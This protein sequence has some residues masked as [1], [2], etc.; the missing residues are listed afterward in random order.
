MKQFQRGSLSISINFAFLLFVGYEQKEEEDDQ[1]SSPVSISVSLSLSVQHMAVINVRLSPTNSSVYQSHIRHSR[2]AIVI[3][4]TLFWWANTA[5]Y[6]PIRTI[7]PT[8][9]TLR[10]PRR[11]AIYVPTLGAEY[12]WLFMHQIIEFHAPNM[13]HVEWADRIKLILFVFCSMLKGLI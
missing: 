7:K 12:F 9:F 13:F 1:W 11:V 2:F 8:R 4:W 3:A 10:L 5:T 6:D